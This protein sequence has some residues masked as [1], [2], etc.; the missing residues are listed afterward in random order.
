[1]TEASHGVIVTESSVLPA[2]RFGAKVMRSF[3]FA[4]LG[5]TLLIAVWISLA[6]AE[7]ELKSGPQPGDE[8]PGPFQV[9]QVTGNKDRVGKF[10]CPVCEHGFG[11]AVLVFFREP[12][13]ANGPIASLFQKLDGFIESHPDLRLGVFG[14][15]LNDGGYQE[16]LVGK[17]E[18]SKVAELA[19]TKAILAKD[20][21]ARQL[22][23]LAEAAKLQHAVLALSTAEGPKEYK[24][25]KDADVTILFYTKHQ[26]QGSYAF[27]KD[28]FTAQEADKIAQDVEKALEGSLKRAKRK[29]A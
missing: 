22:S 13:E 10:V 5:A 3:S 26:I 9:L 21:K 20:E 1:L 16:A 25:N 2:F 28:G 19:L 27:G 14:I 29:K 11:P 12:G 7:G 6:N 18:D 15:S 24:I 23:A 4:P 17:I 8:V